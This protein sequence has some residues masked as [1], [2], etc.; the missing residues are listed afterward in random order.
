MNILSAQVSHLVINFRLLCITHAHMLNQTK[1]RLVVEK[2]K[3]IAC[4]HL[5]TNDNRL[6]LIKIAFYTRFCLKWVNVD[7]GKK[8]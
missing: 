4:L 7:S 6:W 1:I 5:K 8:I 2:T 3:K